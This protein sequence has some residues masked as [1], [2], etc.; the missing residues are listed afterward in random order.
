MPTIRANAIA[1]LSVPTHSQPGRITEMILDAEDN[2]GDPPCL[3]VWSRLLESHPRIEYVNARSC[4]SESERRQ[5]VTG[6]R[7]RQGK[8]LLSW[9][10]SALRYSNRL[11]LSIVDA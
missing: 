6:T 10:W 3:P 11:R 1:A 8:C 5:E 2:R 7:G 4:A 9:P